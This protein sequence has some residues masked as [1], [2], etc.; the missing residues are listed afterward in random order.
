MQHQHISHT[1]R[2]SP[3]QPPWMPWFSMHHR[4]SISRRNR[5]IA[6][7][8]QTKTNEAHFQTHSNA[9]TWANRKPKNV[10]HALPI[11][12][13]AFATRNKRCQFEARK[14]DWCKHS[15]PIK[16]CH[17]GHPVWM[18]LAFLQCITHRQF[19]EYI[20][21]RWLRRKK[22][23]VTHVPQ[24]AKLPHGL[25]WD[26]V[27]QTYKTSAIAKFVVIPMHRCITRKFNWCTHPIMFEI[28]TLATQI[29]DGVDIFVIHPR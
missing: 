22:I 8:D 3:P 27:K 12:T 11:A 16:N 26:Q 28:A 15:T 19:C 13:F 2:L 18:K 17:L 10:Y 1:N 25:P 29:H 21:A 24:H 14:S 23:R 9:A 7:P 5:C 4:S 6:D 20:A